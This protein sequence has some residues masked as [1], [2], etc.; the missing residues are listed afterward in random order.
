MELQRQWAWV[1]SQIDDVLDARNGPALQPFRAELFGCEGFTQYGLSL[2]RSHHVGK[3]RF[4]QATFYPRLQSNL[5]QLRAALRYITELTQDGHEAGPGTEW[6]LDNFP[7]I[8]DQLR[9]ITEGLPPRYYRTLP[10]LQGEPLAGFPRIY[11]LAWAFVAHVDSAFDEDLLTCF[12]KAYQEGSELTQGELW[13]LPTTLRVV[14]VEN[15]RRLADRIASQGAARELAVLCSHHIEHLTL[16]DVQDMQRLMDV[17]GVK[18]IFL[19][20]LAQVLTGHRGVLGDTPAPA[21]DQWLQEAI[22]DLASLQIQQYA[23]HAADHLSV[24]NAV[25]SLRLIGTSDWAGIVAQVS[26]TMRVMQASSVFV[27]EDEASRN[28][29]LHGIERLS[30]RSSGLDESTVARTLIRFMANVQGAGAQAGYWLHGAGRAQLEHALGAQQSIRDLWRSLPIPRTCAYLGAVLAGTLALVAWLL[31]L[32]GAMPMERSGFAGLGLVGLLMLLPASEAVI[33]LVNRLICESATPVHLPRFLLAEGIPPSAQTMVVIPALLSQPATVAQLVHRL[34]LHYL[35]NPEVCAQFA[36]LSDWSDAPAQNM[37]ED[38]RLLEH[39]QA[40]L[41]ALNALHPPRQGAPPRFL[42]LHRARAYSATQRQWIGWERKRGKLEQLVCALAT[43]T[44]G[45][46]L[47]MAELSQV[48]PGTRYVL[49]LDSD[50]ELPPGQLRALVGVAEHPDNQPQWDSAGRTVVQG[51]GILQPRVVSPLPQADASS[52]WQWLFAGQQGIDPYSAATSDVYQDFFGEGSFIGKGLLH[53]S[54]LHAL[55]CQRLPHDRILSHD[56]LE[57]AMV[58]CAVVSN[59][60]VIEAPPLHSDTAAARQHRWS[61][62]DW[63]LLPILWQHRHWGLSP[64]SRWKLLDNLRRTCV[65]PASLVLI[66]AAMTGRGLALPMALALATMAYATGPVVGSLASLLPHRAHAAGRRF[67]IAAAQDLLRAALGGVWNLALLLSQAL[68]QADS[69][70]RTAY[71]LLW[72]R[73]HLLEWTTA[74]S[75]HASIKAGLLSALVRHR[76]ST[77]TAL[78][79]LAGLWLLQA[80][81]A[82]LTLIVLVVWTCTPALVWCMNKPCRFSGR[83]ALPPQDSEMLEGIARDT[84]R[85][86]E[87]CVTQ[88][89]HHLPPDNLQTAP[90]EAIAHRTSPTN[91]GLYLLSAACARKFGWIGTLDLLAR[92]ESTLATLQSMERHQG[93]F[94]NWYDTETLQPLH[95]RYVSTV[96]SGNLSAHLLAVSQACVAL[97]RDPLEPHAAQQA[98]HASQLRLQAHHSHEESSWIHADQL[99]TSQS[100]ARDIAASA[101]GEAPSI[102]RKLLD[103]AHR[104]DQLAWDADFRFLFDAKRHLLHIGYRV[105]EQALDAS[106]YDLLASEARTTSLLAITKGDVPVRHWKALGRPF[107]ASGRNAVLR[108]WSGSMFEYLMPTLVMADPHGSALDDA[109]RSALREQIAFVRGQGIPWGISESAYAGRD[110]TLAYQYAPQGVPRLALRRTPMADKVIA[111]Y[112]TALACQID[113]PAACN[114]FRAL[115]ALSARGRYGFFEALDF[116]P[117]LQAPGERFTRV[118][119][120][121]AHHQGMTIVAL[122]NVL[123]QGAAQ[124][125]LMGHPRIEAVSSLLQERAP[126]EL[127]RLYTPP[128]LGLPLQSPNKRPGHVSRTVI[129]GAQAPEPTHLLSNGRYSVTLRAN[130]AGWSRWGSADI[131][132]WRDDVLRDA[133]GSFVYLRLGRHAAPVSVTSNPAPD[134]DALYRSTFQQDRVYFD[135]RWPELQARTTVWVSPEDDI[136]L[137][138]VVLNNLSKHTV[139]L[140]LLSAFEVSLASA[141]A[142]EVHPAFSNMFVKADWLPAQQALRFERVPRVL[143]ENTMRAAHFVAHASGEILGLRCQTDRARWQGRNHAASQPLASLE[144]VPG[145]AAALVTQLDPVSVLGVLLQIAPG[146]QVSVTFALAA[147]DSEARLMAVV[148]KY[149]QPSYVERASVMSATLAGGPAAPHRPRPDY[150]PTLQLLTTALVFTLPRAQTQRAKNRQDEA[151]TSDRRV[152]WPLGISGDRPLILVNAGAPQGLGLLRLL[153]QALCEWSRGGVVCDL[154]VLNSEVHSYHMPV[155][156]ELKLLC[157]QHETDRKARSGSAVTSL[158]VLRQDEI[159]SEQTA[160]LQR[161]ARV[162]LYADGRALSHQIKSWSA[163]YAAHSR[164]LRTEAQVH[165]VGVQRSS[166]TAAPAPTGA[167]TAGTGDFQFDVGPALRPIRPWANILANPGFGGQ[168]TESGGGNTWAV[169][170]RLNQLTAWQNDPVADT[171]AE[172]L[173]LQDRHT[174]EVWSVAPS[175]WG[176]AGA[177]YHVV[178][179]QGFTDISHRRGDLEVSVRWCVDIATAI[180]QVRIRVTNQGA[181]KAHLRIVGMVEWMMGEKRADRATVET[182][183]CFAPPPHQGLWGLLCTQTE[184]GA[185]FGGGTAFFCEGNSLRGDRSHE[186]LDWTCDRSAFF[187]TQGQLQLPSSLGQ[188]SGY[189]LDPCAAL[190]RLTTLRPGSTLEQVYLTGYAASPQAARALLA[191]AAPLPPAGREQAIR[192]YWSTLLG[193]TQVR[194]PDP[195]FDVMVNRWLLYQVQSSR[196]WAKAG[197]YQVSG[198][199]GYRDQLQ[200]AMAFAWAD[201]P[202]LRAQILLCASRQFQ[203]GDVQHWWHTPGGAGVRTHFSDDLLWLP[204]ACAHYLQATGDT[205]LLRESVPFLDAAPIPDGAE[206]AY[207]TPQ[208]SAVSASLYEH[209]ARTI[210][211]S[212]AVGAHGLPLMGAGDWNDG[213][214]RVGP[215]GQGESVWLA[216]FLC[217]IVAD[218]IPLARGVG[219]ADRAARWEAAQQGWRQALQGPGWDGQWYKRAFFDDGSPLGSASQSEARIDLIAQAWAVLSTPQWSARQGVAM[220]AV[221]THLVLPNAGLIQLL[222]PPL[223][224]AMPSAGYIQ[225]YPPGVR[226]NGGQYTHAGVWALMAAAALAVRQ[227][228]CSTS[229]GVATDTPYRY[230]TCLSPAHRAS[231]PEWGRHYAIEPYVM[232][233]DVYSQPPYVGRGGWS[234]YTGSAGWMHRAAVESILGLHLMAE[235]LFFTPCL[236]AHWPEA[237][238]TLARDGR[239]LHFILVRGNRAAAMEKGAAAGAR[240]LQVA[241]RL[242]WRDLPAHS[243]F[244]I[245][246][247]AVTPQSAP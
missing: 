211:R 123:R 231:H 94:L 142:D 97:A 183:P 17:R 10:A 15:L 57:G 158:H 44:R 38:A 179:G 85:I 27:A 195:L 143:G 232:A 221:E 166:G 4:G 150:L 102:T 31:H 80:P 160:T 146:E 173:L 159:T 161:L 226:E 148:D 228:A 170:S 46:F 16:K 169:N 203:A 216:W 25:A 63:Q 175:A 155:Q 54:A 100:A 180:K 225:A 22:P 157:D 185:G 230:F 20:H 245:P 164:P 181:R 3:A 110:Q 174:Q 113:T 223:V 210:D 218:W 149:R 241:E 236:P 215:A 64:I 101:A 65:A 220:E 75:A 127:P 189:G 136:E 212:L 62:G 109:N 103:L 5:R 141:A 190:S 89:D 178:H 202:L 162:R 200:D 192:Q 137:R 92:L 133:Y 52:P 167:F 163:H 128:P 78:A 53:V 196:L 105:E 67:A 2:G 107:F 83:R 138:K 29:T 177:T 114:N 49:T 227:P 214:N 1:P 198:A 207:E 24:S 193:A 239:S 217:A 81:M 60:A 205:A 55:L 229:A 237:E 51:Y 130:G 69:I 144:P 171:P 145:Q 71:R 6:L 93:H 119:T 184:A 222:T 36:L 77:L 18:R 244:V 8:E 14:L 154:V 87:R 111:P 152:L 73:R 40:L 176:D 74:E 118:S 12:L 42:L 120:Y 242:R 37:P 11:H 56:L 99:V 33:A 116:T 140:E 153:V 59:A 35:A 246:L 219:D 76:A 79:L 86:F 30:V 188:R 208:V 132:R 32:S 147:C 151:S 206:D 135:A 39:A 131:T 98:L 90:F 50:T 125:W 58:G 172:W 34:H 28:A 13:A 243:C 48:A 84:W 47:D 95:P 121:M 41:Q 122:A 115:A 117:G 186:G 88:D 61:R 238:L 106:F 23:D 66:V 213:M 126:R 191:Q 26:R 204:F 19:T 165:Q 91:I 209:A 156:Q 124:R 82:P 43:G 168:V 235:E 199:T 240:V 104:L 233:G 21:M 112:A 96:D 72:S 70:V 68:L 194:T 134:P 234:W 139:E 7:L 201:P 45:P 187:G 108:S 9:E 182:A 224:H 247:A 129:P 197:F